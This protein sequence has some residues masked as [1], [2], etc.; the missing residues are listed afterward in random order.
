MRSWVDVRAGDWFYN[1]VMEATNMILEDGSNFVN[2]IYYNR[3]EE[4]APYVY[5]EHSGE[6]G[7]TVF[8]LSAEITVTENN[9]L[10]VYVDGIQ[11]VY[12]SITANPS[13]GTDV[14]LYTAPRE[15]AIVAFASHGIP[16]VDQF[17]RPSAGGSVSYPSHTLEHASQY[18]YTPYNKRLLEYLYAPGRALYRAQVPDED[19][20]NLSDQEVAKKHIGFSQD[21]YCVSPEGVVYLPYNLNHVTIKMT[22]ALRS[23]KA[24]TET[25]RATSPLVLHNDRFFPNAYINRAEAFALIG[26]LRDIF[27]SRFTDIEPP[28]HILEQTIISYAGQTVFRLNGTYPAGEEKLL[29][30]VDGVQQV[31]GRDYQEFDDHTVLFLKPLAQGREV[32]FYYQKTQSSRFPDVGKDS[33]MV[34]RAPDGSTSTVP[35]D[36]DADTS[37]WASYVLA[38]EDERYGGGAGVLVNGKQITNFQNGWPVVNTLYDPIP[39]S[40]PEQRWFMPLSTLSRAEA[41]SFLNRFRKWGIER[42]KGVSQGV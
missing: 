26:R 34:V 4:G 8:T 13:G 20:A 23:G 6:T 37:F 30:R 39:G 28:S 7:K 18:V 12:R 19:W 24:Y 36:G 27:Y 35:I 10:F 16:V 17:G 15:G 42:F 14:E 33:Q 25:F 1:E 11:T 29:V 38:M 9:P 2:G 31:A 41:V 32:Y 40:D 22:Y 3:F 5:E 21:V